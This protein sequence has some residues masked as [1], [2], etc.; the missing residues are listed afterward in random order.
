MA[1]KLSYF[2]FFLFKQIYYIRDL[3]RVFFKYAVYQK[4]NF[5]FF[6]YIS[7]YYIKLHILFCYRI[8]NLLFLQSQINCAAFY[9]KFVS[10]NIHIFILILEILSLLMTLFLHLI[11]SS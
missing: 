4:M 6:C 10:I 5:Y 7:Y 2:V 11:D 1:F 8:K 9:I 3:L